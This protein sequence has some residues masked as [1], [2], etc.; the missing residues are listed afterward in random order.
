MRDSDGYRSRNRKLR[1][2]KGTA[3]ASSLERFPGDLRYVRSQRKTD[4]EVGGKSVFPIGLQ[5]PSP[6]VARGHAYDRVFARV[7]GRITSEQLYAEDPLFQS[8]RAAGNL[9]LHDVVKELTAAMTPLE[10]FA[11]HYF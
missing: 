5:Q 2:G 4:T 10:G 3:N 8:G 1:D 9:L 6:Y 11:L 7:V